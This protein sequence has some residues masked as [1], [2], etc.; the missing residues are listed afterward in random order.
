MQIDRRALLGWS[1]VAGA[2]L[3]MPALLS[4][5]ALAAGSRSAIERALLGFNK[6]PGSVAYMIRVGRGGRNG[7]ET[8]KNATTPMFVGSAI[9]TFIL[10]RFLMDVEDGR[11]NPTQPLT[12][13]DSVR[14]LSSPVFLDL[15]GK[16]SGSS[17]LEAMIAHS[18]NTATD[19]AMAQVGVKRVRAFIASARLSSV[20]I[21]TSTR[22]LFSYLAGAPYGV[23][24]GWQGVQQILNGKLFGPARS[25]M[26][27]QETMQATAADMVQYYERILGGEFIRSAEMQTEFRRISSMA[28]G[29]WRVVPVNTAAYGKGGSI[30]WNNFNCFCLPGQMLIGATTPAT[31]FFCVNWTG[32]PA[33]IPAVRDRFAAVIKDVLAETAK[34]FS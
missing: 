16:T 3:A 28:D 24:V 14:T 23:D 7:L 31:F 27:D 11:L 18:D 5:P 22:R 32:K 12:I 33:T 29:L 20:R 26:N 19:I 13:D 30:E 4:A 9:K 10:A 17:V 21:P 8:S 25:P 6:L 34:A 15:A 1:G 2:S